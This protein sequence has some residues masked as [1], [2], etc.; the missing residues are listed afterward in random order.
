[1]VDGEGTNN[2]VELV[3]EA[4]GPIEQELRGRLDAELDERDVLAIESALLKAFIGGMR[5]ILA[6][7]AE[8]AVDQG[9]TV[10]GFRRRPFDASA[11]L[12]EERLPTLDPWA[13]RHEQGG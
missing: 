11:V 3:M 8:L 5:T 12:D 9:P 6:E 10:F 4:V 13:Q 2:I 1:M 7:Q